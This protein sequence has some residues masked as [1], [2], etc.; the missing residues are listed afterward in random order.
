MEGEPAILNKSIPFAD[1]S[2]DSY[3]FEAVSW[4]HQNG[5]VNGVTENEFAPN[6]NITREQIAAILYRYAEFKGYDVGAG[7][8]QI[9]EFEDYEDISDYAMNAMTWAVNTGLMKGKTETTLNP[10]DNATRAEIAAMIQ[11]FVEG[12]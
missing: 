2:G 5:I 3:Y 8:M 10:K 6:Q 11:R 7:G 1:V 9:R 4:A 12:N